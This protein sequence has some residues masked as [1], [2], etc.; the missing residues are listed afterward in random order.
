MEPDKVAAVALIGSPV[1]ALT[2]VDKAA[3]LQDYASLVAAVAV[4]LAQAAQ[5]AGLAQPSVD[6]IVLY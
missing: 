3:A 6:E 4:A 5:L 1:V 2:A